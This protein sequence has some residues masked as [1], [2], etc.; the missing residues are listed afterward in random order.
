M[1][2]RTAKHK[3]MQYHFSEPDWAKAGESE[4]KEWIAFKEWVDIARQTGF[5]NEAWNAAL[6]T[7]AEEAAC[8]ASARGG[9]GR[10]SRWPP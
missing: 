6:H 10:R 4:V 7:V 9:G 8:A 5:V 3:L 2:L 1:K